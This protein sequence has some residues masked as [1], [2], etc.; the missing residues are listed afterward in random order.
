ML[1]KAV[2]GAAAGLVVGFK[3]HVHLHGLNITLKRAFVK[4]KVIHGWWVRGA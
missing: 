4:G 3:G 2:T 1:V